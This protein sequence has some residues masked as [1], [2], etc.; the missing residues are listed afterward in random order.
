ME[1]HLQDGFQFVNGNLF[2]RVIVMKWLSIYFL[3]KHVRLLDFFVLFPLFHAP[4]CIILSK[5]KNKKGRKTTRPQY[6]LKVKG[7]HTLT[8]L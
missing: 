5:G 8:D 4:L 7:I 1:M 6:T 2:K 3:L